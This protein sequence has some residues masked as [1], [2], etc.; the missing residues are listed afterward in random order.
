M[1]T[2]ISF[3]LLVCLLCFNSI[4]AE[5]ISPN[6]KHFYIQLNGL[7]EPDYTYEYGIIEYEDKNGAVKKPFARS[8]KIKAEEIFFKEFE[9]AYLS[10]DEK[11]NDVLFYIHGQWGN[12]NEFF[13]LSTNAMYKDIFS[14]NQNQTG[15]CISYIWD[16]KVIYKNNVKIALNKGTK[17]G[18]ITDRSIKLMEQLKDKEKA[19]EVNFLCHSMGNKVFQGIHCVLDS[20]DYENPPIDI[21]IQAG[22]D[23]IGN[24]YE[25]GQPM[26]N[27]EEVVEQ[28]LIYRHNNDRTL[29]MAKLLH[30]HTRM[31]LD[32]LDSIEKAPNNITIVDVSIVDDNN[33]FASKFSKHRY[34]FTSPTVR[35]DMLYVWAGEKP[36]SVKNR[37]PLISNRVYKL[38]Y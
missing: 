14:N 1:K 18:T 16:C 32:G 10:M 21:L 34:Y 12:T 25:E 15:I 24:I 3:L 13:E 30:D 26:E 23:L 27:I 7:E 17:F 37:K 20:A 38:L 6:F 2:K 28:I 11:K 4:Q 22:S 35:Q 8:E 31:G 5:G 19:S 33:D 29:K 36:D 9:S